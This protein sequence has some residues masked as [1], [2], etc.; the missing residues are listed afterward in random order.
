MSVTPI[1]AYSGTVPNR[2]TQDAIAFSAAADTFM[3]W[4]CATFPTAL[5]TFVTQINAVASSCDADAVTAATS[6]AMLTAAISTVGSSVWVSGTTYAIGD[7]RWS[8]INY[9]IYRRKTTGAGTTDP[10]LDTANW[11]KIDSVPA[12]ASNAGAILSTDGTIALWAALKTI[13]GSSLL[14]GT[15]IALQALLVSGTNIK[16]INGSSLL[17][18]TD[19]ALLPIAGGTM[20]GAITALR[21]TKTAISASNINLATGNVF[22]KTI[23]GNTTFTLSNV[24]ATGT[25]NSFILDLTNG[26][27]YTVTWFSGVKWPNG[28]APALSTSGRD[29]LG[30][31]SHDGGTTWNGFFNK[32]MA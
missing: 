22:T 6:T 24:A 32:G 25:V 29:I 14:G 13:N 7:V 26:G 9:Q 23:T 10:S 1:T 28:T 27:A 18:G 5:G 17:G 12:M 19:I 3:P 2:A 4:L 31:M 8:T 15:D 21:E 30:F 16:T 20:T 11:V